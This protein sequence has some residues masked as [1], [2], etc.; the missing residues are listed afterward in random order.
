MQPVRILCGSLGKVLHYEEA[1]IIYLNLSS[2][3]ELMGLNEGR[4]N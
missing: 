3:Y 2:V 1:P 4:R